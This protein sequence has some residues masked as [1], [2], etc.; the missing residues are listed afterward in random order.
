MIFDTVT[1]LK[2]VIH[3]T[4]HVY[5]SSFDP[6]TSKSVNDHMIELHFWCI[7]KLFECALLVQIRSWDYNLKVDQKCKTLKHKFP[8]KWI[9]STSAC[10]STSVQ[11]IFHHVEISFKDWVK[12][13]PSRIMVCSENFIYK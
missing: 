11:Y 12:I 6:L 1:Y 2:E 3:V 9:I 13:E 5:N 10:I 7:L 4:A 8:I